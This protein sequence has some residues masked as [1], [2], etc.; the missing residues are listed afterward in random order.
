M[1]IPLQKERFFVK[2]KD[3][4]LK[5]HEKTNGERTNSPS[6]IFHTK[7]FVKIRQLQAH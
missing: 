2:V 5:F 3:A 1:P 4:Q 6:S 7:S